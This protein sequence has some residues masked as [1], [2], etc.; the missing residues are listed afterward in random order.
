[1]SD[2]FKYSLTRICLRS[3][4]FT[5]S[6]K[7]TGI[8][9]DEG[10]FLALDTVHDKEIELAMASPRVVTGLADFLAAHEL[11]VN[12]E[13]QI[14]TLDDG[15]YA[16]T[17][18]KRVRKPNYDRDDVV[19][20]LLDQ[21]SDLVPLSEA[22]IREL[23]T[24]IPPAADVGGWLEHDPRF[25]KRAGRWHRYAPS[26]ELNG[27]PNDIFLDD[28]DGRDVDDREVDDREDT[29]ANHDPNDVSEPVAAAPHS[30]HHE[31]RTSQQNRSRQDDFDN[32]DFDNGDFDTDD[33]IVAASV[34]AS[35]EIEGSLGSDP[36]HS[37]PHLGDAPLGD[38]D[39]YHADDGIVSSVRHSSKPYRGDLGSESPATSGRTSDIP[40]RNGVT[41]D[42]VTRDSVT[43]DSITRDS[44]TRDSV[45]QDSV[46]Q[47]SRGN[48]IR[49]SAA[50]SSR[51]S[52]PRVTV[53]SYPQRSVTPSDLAIGHEQS[54]E[55][56]ALHGKARDALSRFGFR[57]EVLSPGNLLAHA[58]LGRYRYSVFVYLLPDEG[59][60]DWAR[61]LS[62]RREQGTT[63]LAVFGSHHD[64]LKLGSPADMANATL[65][66]WQGLERVRSLATTVPISPIDLE[67]HFKRDGLI[68]QSIPRF[69]SV[70]QKRIAERG[71]FSAVVTR[72]A[73]F[74]APSIFLLDD[75]MIDVDTSRDQVL[76]V[77]TL[78][79][80]A[81]FHLVSK[82]DDGEFCLRFGVSQGLLHLSDYA[83]SLRDRLP[84]RTSERFRGRGGDADGAG[85][86][87]EAGE[88]NASEF[89]IISGLDD[90]RNLA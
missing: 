48:V 35:A 27:D 17:P 57:V 36:H 15:R 71:I 34:A 47:D 14:R 80:L 18:L 10:T 45:T 16:F 55:E 72:L 1:M 2:D 41:R 11:D 33:M 38:H 20:A 3:G 85:A 21:V 90:D 9:P 86:D 87:D 37:D 52:V 79:S 44:V 89:A 19:A 42:S 63:Y 62:R 69:E 50:H 88:L 56:Y 78:L 74:K 32:G 7:L 25:I 49:D 60:V 39:T 66:S 4:Q 58:D 81:P 59:R 84:E 46:T 24:D 67:P 26:A 30:A 77:L 22:E 65:W 82:V 29:G 23:F 28:I 61:L 12:D 64:L 73:S 51:R 31:H 76:S 75:V 43:Q 83:L 8:F 68:E 6:R 40:P 13:V 70:I 54:P 5:L 53:T